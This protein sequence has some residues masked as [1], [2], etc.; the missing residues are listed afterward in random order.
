MLAKIWVSMQDETKAVAMDLLSIL[1]AGDVSL[2]AG[3]GVSIPNPTNLP[4]ANELKWLLVQALVAKVGSADRE[5]L[6][7]YVASD[8]LELML[9]QLAETFGDVAVEEL[10]DIFTLGEPNPLSCLGSA[11]SAARLN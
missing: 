1:G 4:S 6:S 2:F 3:A 8:M 5:L 9:E 7:K 10:L 11:I